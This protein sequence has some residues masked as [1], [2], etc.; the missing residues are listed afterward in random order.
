VHFDL[1][2]ELETS[3]KALAG[4]N[5]YLAIKKAPELTLRQYVNSSRDRKIDILT[6]A[7]KF[8]NCTDPQ[9]PEEKK[10]LGQVI[11]A[12]NKCYI[13]AIKLEIDHV[14]TIPYDI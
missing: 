10:H 14:N 5:H 3:I 6:R 8:F 12:S 4:I 13:D 7:L 2:N 9:L 11:L 1:F